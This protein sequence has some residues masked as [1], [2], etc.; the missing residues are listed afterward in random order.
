MSDD[1]ESISDSAAAASLIGHSPDSEDVV[2]TKP[3]RGNTPAGS[4]KASKFLCFAILVCVTAV[5]VLMVAVG[6]R[7][8]LSRSNNEERDPLNRAESLLAEYPVIDG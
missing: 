4:K 8:G 1:E 2:A 6:L 5:V 3:A 7:T